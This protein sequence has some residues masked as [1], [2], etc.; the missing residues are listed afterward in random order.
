MTRMARWALA[1]VGAIAVAALAAGTILAQP[2][3]ATLRLGESRT[4]SSTQLRAGDIVAC[5][6]D[7]KHITASVPPHG[8]NG[9]Y[10]GPS[11]GTSH[12]ASHVRLA[13]NKSIRLQIFGTALGS[14]FVAC[15]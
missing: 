8:S 5:Q 14:Y 7:G 9:P 4:F 10:P 6:G 3:S 15:S 12:P 13:W 2:P 11:S 1:L